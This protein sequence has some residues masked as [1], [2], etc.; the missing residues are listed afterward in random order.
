MRWA[1]VIEASTASPVS[2]ELVRSAC[3]A[4]RPRSGRFGEGSIGQIKATARHVCTSGPVGIDALTDSLKTGGCV[5]YSSSLRCTQVSIRWGDPDG[6]S[7]AEVEQ[8]VSSHEGEAVRI[9]T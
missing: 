5:G 3:G 7:G 9:Q 1:W 4:A 6:E 2:A 8:S